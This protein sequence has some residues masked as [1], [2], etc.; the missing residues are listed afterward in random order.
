MAVRMAWDDSQIRGAMDELQPE[1]ERATAD[2]EEALARQ[3]EFTPAADMMERLQR[4]IELRDKLA[5][6]QPVYDDD[7][8]MIGPPEEATPEFQAEVAAE[9]VSDLRKIIKSITVS[10]DFPDKTGRLRKGETRPV[11]LERYMIESAV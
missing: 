8:N 6:T 11:Q 2:Y 9:F 10:P 7:G 4:G 3:G 1:L 5:M